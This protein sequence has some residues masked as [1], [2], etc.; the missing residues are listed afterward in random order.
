IDTAW[1]ELGTAKSLL[2]E[3]F[4]KFYREASI[5]AV[6]SQNG[7]VKTWPFAE[8]HQDNGILS[9]SMITATNSEALSPAAKYY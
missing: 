2:D 7:A 6:R 9:P 1:A 3:S 4:V 8:T 5:I